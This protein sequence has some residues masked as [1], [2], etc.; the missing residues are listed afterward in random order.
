MNCYE[1][2]CEFDADMDFYHA[3]MSKDGRWTVTQKRGLRGSNLK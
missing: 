2:G 1:D 3:H